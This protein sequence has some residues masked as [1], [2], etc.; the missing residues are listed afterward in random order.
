MNQ[1]TDLVALGKLGYA[2]RILELRDELLASVEQLAIDGTPIVAKATL[3]TARNVGLEE[4]LDAALALPESTERE[5][6]VK[7]VA[8]RDIAN[9][10]AEARRLDDAEGVVNEITMSISY[11][12]AVAYTELA[13]HSVEALKPKRASRL[14][15]LAEEIA[16]AQR[17]GYF[18][19]AVYREVAVVRMA[20]GAVGDAIDTFNTAVAAARTAPTLQERA[21]ALSRIATRMSDA[22]LAS[23]ADAV[24]NLAVT[25]AESVN[26]KDMLGY[27]RYEISGSAAFAGYFDLALEMLEKTPA[28]PFGAT[29]SLRSV[30]QR[31]LAWGLARADRYPEAL[32]L[33]RQIAT[34]REQVHALSR[35]ALLSLKPG[36]AA[37]SRYL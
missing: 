5:A 1:R 12:Q 6:G 9:E 21:R 13:R 4:G 22:G 24:L 8:L 11:Y 16:A 10:F 35:V 32:R 23:Q 34:V 36:A 29:E 25:V 15:A 20:M 2:P 37:P 33:A 7:A 30:A 19:G 27:T 31:D 18:R 3:V 26:D 17:N 14:L 28:V